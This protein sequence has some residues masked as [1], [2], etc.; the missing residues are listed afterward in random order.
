MHWWVRLGTHAEKDYALKTSSIY[1]HIVLNANLVIATPGASASLVLKLQKG[2]VIDPMT[3][4]FAL[5][6]RYLMTKSKAK[7]TRGQ[8]M[9]KRTYEKLGDRYGSPI[10]GGVGRQRLQ[11][12][13]F[14]AQ[15]IQTFVANVY[16]FQVRAMPDTWEEDEEFREIAAL[17]YVGPHAVL[18]PYFYMFPGPRFKGWL[19]LNV[20]LASAFA[21]CVKARVA[22]YAPICIDEGLL[23]DPEACIRIADAV[24]AL[25][26]AGYVLWVSD[27]R[28]ERA[29]KARLRALA[30]LVSRLSQGGLRQVVNAHGGFFSLALRHFGMTGL[31]HSFGYGEHRD[32]TPV[33]GG[34]LPPVKYYYPPLRCLLIP[35]YVE[36]ILPGIEVA[37]PAAF[38]KRVCGCS[39]CRSVVSQ[40]IDEF[41][42][43]YEFTVNENGNE[44]ATPEAYDRCRYHYLLARKQEIDSF[45]SK[46]LDDIIGTLQ[47][48]S[49]LYEDE[50]G[51]ADASYLRTWA[52]VL[53]EK[54]REA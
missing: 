23:D 19:D 53:R 22:W 13:D 51:V 39:I 41:E 5:N 54:A 10:A 42:K 29:G 16:S 3:Y 4:A 18:S 14:N 31:S 36:T 45:Q 17:R 26:C 52:E 2:F 30:D 40:S 38:H 27:L 43:F 32:V 28:E 37:T 33:L 25:P 44:V 6:P 47:H 8:L 35:T 48:S 15:N 50:T 46:S 1:D 11:P 12:N 9:V 34:G 49:E 7:S 24:S 21:A 20:E